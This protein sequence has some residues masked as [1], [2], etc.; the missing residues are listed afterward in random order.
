LRE[1]E[2]SSLGKIENVLE[3]EL[4]VSRK[5]AMIAVELLLAGGIQHFLFFLFF[6]KSSRMDS[7]AKNSQLLRKQRSEIDMRFDGARI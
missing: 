6:A 7:A 2:L 5:P 1:L 4:L 3:I